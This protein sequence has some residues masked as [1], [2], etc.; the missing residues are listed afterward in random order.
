M[1]IKGN[2]I[3]VN[4]KGITINEL[5]PIEIKNKEF[6]LIMSI[7]KQASNQVLEMLNGVNC[8]YKNIFKKEII[9]HITSR[10]KAPKSILD[11]MKKKN[12]ELNYQNLINNINDIAGVRVICP[13]KDDVYTIV[14]IVEKV[15]NWNL[16]IEKDYIRNPKKSGYSGYHMIVEVPVNINEINKNEQHLL[17]SSNER[18][19]LISKESKQKTNNWQLKNIIFVKVEIQIRTMAMDFWATNEHRMKYK[20]NKKMSY[21]DSK[22]LSIY[23]KVINIIDERISKIN[24]KQE[25]NHVL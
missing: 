12:L 21:I 22:K 19:E 13:A 2:K 4:E 3:D 16:I 24:K 15:P 9:N 6:D 14:S 8:E 20:S 1:S 10:I 25:L 23:A 17:E 7:Y 18:F 11:K 5:M